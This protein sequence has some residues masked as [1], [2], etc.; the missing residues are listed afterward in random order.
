MLRVEDPHLEARVEPD[1]VGGHPPERQREADLDEQL[2]A[3]REAE[4][5]ALGDLDEVVGEAERGGAERDAEDRQALGVARREHQVGD[6]DRDEHDQPAH[7][8]RPALAWC[9]AGPPRGLKSYYY[10]V[11]YRFT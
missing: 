5:A 8:R 7:R 3:R 2:P 1:L 6:G 4:R 10:L 9:S 11:H